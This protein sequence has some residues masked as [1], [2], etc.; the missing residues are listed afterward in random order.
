MNFNTKFVIAKSHEKTLQSMQQK[1]FNTKFVIA[2][3]CVLMV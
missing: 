3:F 1:D 2:K